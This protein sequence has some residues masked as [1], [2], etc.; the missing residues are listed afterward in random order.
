MK[1]SKKFIEGIQFEYL[2]ANLLY[3]FVPIQWGGPRESDHLYWSPANPFIYVKLLSMVD[4]LNSKHTQVLFLPINHI[5]ISTLPNLM[6]ILIH[7]RFYSHLVLW[8]LTRCYHEIFLCLSWCRRKKPWHL[9]CW[10]KKLPPGHKD[11]DP[12]RKNL[13]FQEFTQDIMRNA[14]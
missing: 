3:S 11:K 4:W 1:C 9:L 12:Q 6:S 10:H 5:I 7:R 14:K 2:D 8:L 13:I